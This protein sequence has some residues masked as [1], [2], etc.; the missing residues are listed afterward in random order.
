MQ[1]DK[2][3]NFY[4]TYFELRK[5]KSKPKLLIHVCCGACSIYPLVFLVDLFDITLY[6]TNSNIYNK[7]EF[8]KRLLAMKKHV[9]FVN[10][11]FKSNINY[12]VGEYNY[13]EFKQFLS[14]YK[15]EKEGGTRCK[16]CIAKRIKET[17]DFALKNNYDAF[18]SIM[19]ISRNKDAIYINRIGKEVSK[20]QNKCI[21]VPFDFKKNNGQDIG[22][23]IGAKE[24]VYRQDFC[25][26]EFSL[27]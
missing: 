16:I 4:D 26:C 18:S 14:P 8:D 6:F 10:S 12:V 25:G 23:N 22:V 13:Q 15:N 7:D 1:K 21:F 2:Y 20:D 5:R 11:L 9:D 27:R 19:S 24:H 3:S 17:Y